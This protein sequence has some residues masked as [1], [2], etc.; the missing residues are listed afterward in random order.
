MS[1]RDLYSPEGRRDPYPIYRELL[2]TSPVHREPVSDTWWVFDYEGVKR[3][4]TDH[5]TFGS[6]LASATHQSPDWLV[7]E[8]PPRHTRLRALVRR[9]FSRQELAALERPIEAQCEKLM[10]RGQGE[11]TVDIVATLA[12]PLPVYVISELMG[13]PPDDRPMCA[14]W[15]KTVMD[16]SHTVQGGKPAADAVAAYRVVRGEMMTYLQELLV[17]QQHRDTLLT[18]LARATVDEERL[19]EAEIFGFFELLLSAGHETTTNLISNALL[20]F[21]EYPEQLAMVRESPALLPAAVEEVLRYRSP[22]QLMFRMTRR[23]TTLHGH[24]IPAGKLVLPVIGAANRDDKQFQEPDRFHIQRDTRAQLAFG[25]GIHFCIG[26]AL[27][28]M[29]ATI[30]LRTF[31]RRVGS[32]TLAPEPWEA[33]QAL[34]V[35]GPR[36]LLVA[37]TFAAA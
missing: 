10:R 17:A 14:R 4:L 8:D 28:R 12:G 29:E 22:G 26:S 9:A 27:A 25:H 24:V 36:R 11:Q 3:V 34:H 19:S 2:R 31:L 15:S 6:R 23:E 5:D 35:L 30:A 21:A 20:C 7:F 33:H 18:R 16:L 13:I 1:L 32:F 37:A